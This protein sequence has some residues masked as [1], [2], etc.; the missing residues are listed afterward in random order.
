MRPG[1]CEDPRRVLHVLADF[2]EV[3]QG[4]AVGQL[5]HGQAFEVVTHADFVSDAD[6]AVQLDAILA[7]QADDRLSH[8]V[9]F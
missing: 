4:V 5:E 3:V 7:D 1:S 8:R 6:A 9:A 2:A